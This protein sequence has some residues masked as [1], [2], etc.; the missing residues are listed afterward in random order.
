[1]GVDGAAEALNGAVAHAAGAFGSFEVLLA[2]LGELVA[3]GADLAQFFVKRFEGFLEALDFLG[4]DACLGGKS[5]GRE[6]DA[7]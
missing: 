7:A 2:E 6:G 1:M 3:L 5:G 4:I